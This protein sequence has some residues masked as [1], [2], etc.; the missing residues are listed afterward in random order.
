MGR[1]SPEPGSGRALG[2]AI[3]Y[4]RQY[5]LD[6]AGA[7]LALI[8][9]SAANL[10]VPQ[11][12]RVAIDRGVDGRNGTVVA[13]AAAS[14]VGLALVRG[15]SSF[16]QGYL[17]ER[18]SQGVAFDLR[19]ALFARIERLSFAYF[20]RVEAGQLISRIT[21]DV[22]QIRQ[23][24]GTGVIQLASAFIMLLG[25]TTLLLIINWRLALVA[26]AA[27]P[28]ILLVLLRFVRSV[29]PIFGQLQRAIGKLNA[30]LQEDLVGMR[31]IRIFG[32]EQREIAR[33]RVANDELLDR[34]VAALNAF[35]NNFPLVF[36]AGN[37]GLLGVVWIGGREV[38]GAQLTIGE[39]V[40]FTAYLNYLLFPILTIG[41]QMATISRAGASALRVFDVLD[42]PDDL[43]ERP[44][45]RVLPHLNGGIE[46][47][48]VHFRYPGAEQ[49]ILS[50]IDLTIQS[51]QTAAIIGTTGSGKSSLVSLISRFYDVSSGAVLIDGQDVRE[52]T[53]SSLRG[54]I[55]IV[56][57]ETLLFSGTIRDNIAYG[58]PEASDAEI[59]QA[60]QA[61]QAAEFIETLPAGFD[62]IV[63]ER[64]LGLS[65]GQRQRIAIARALL[66]DPRILI[67]DDSTSS[68]DARTEA[69]IQ[70][71]LDRLMREGGRTVVVIAQRI[72]T[73]RDADIIVVLDA[74]KVVA[75]G[76][77]AELLEES[78]IY[79]E[80]IQSQL[81][82]DRTTEAAMAGGD[83]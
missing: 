5:R 43:V 26:L 30:V 9:V 19:E 69:A 49:E 76:T 45:A 74:G 21:N 37:V 14:L 2:R 47:R 79:N 55:G 62:T 16:L 60:A 41:F 40:A 12:L 61:A 53:L 59:V 65:G 56:M 81:V 75:Q 73:V 66:V 28:L 42:E 32:Q 15:L 8:V 50:G 35:G 7:L 77:H 52:V 57:Q 39:L 83:R 18:A 6:A 54:Q 44:D 63:G 1:M 72:S 20:D 48:N 11:V 68:V 3:G 25:T 34:N 38:I 82:D 70:E 80:I 29:F 46:F 23:F 78:A 64:G 33:Y 36:F 51:G 71:A 22:E 27:I 58:R 13:L 31:V 24:A 4:L 17:S 10:A 67:L